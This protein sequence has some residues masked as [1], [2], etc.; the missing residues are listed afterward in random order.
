MIVAIHQPNYIPWAGFFHKMANSDV[1]VLLDNVKHSKS[2]VTNRNIIKSNDNELLLSIPLQNKE[3]I[4]KDLILMEPSKNLRKHWNAIETNY[5]EA[6]Y[7]NYFSDV[8][9]D[10]YSNEWKRLADMNIAI[11]RAIKKVLNI[12]AEILIASELGDMNGK[13]SERNLNICKVLKAN[14]YL[15]GLGAKNYNDHEA[16][17]NEQIEIIYNNFQH[18]IY[19]QLGKKFIP[20]LS[21]IDLIFNCG[22]SSKQYLSSTAL[23]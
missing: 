11:I 23:T 4:I 6:I 21:I 15:S 5:K 3:S 2:S 17:S 22:S 9:K 12:P 7:W 8:L 13:G 16:F 14:T 20:K 1:F 18:P 10:I 19:P